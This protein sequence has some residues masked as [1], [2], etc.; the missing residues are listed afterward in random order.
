[1]KVDEASRFWIRVK[2]FVVWTT[3]VVVVVELNLS[4]RN[5]SFSTSDGVDFWPNLSALLTF[6][7]A[8]ER[9]F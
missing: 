4:V 1:L 6:F 2:V 5:F 9:L 7:S 3:V 8:S